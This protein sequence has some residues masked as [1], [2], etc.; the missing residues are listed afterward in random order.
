[1]KLKKSNYVTAALLLFAL[2]GGARKAEAINVLTF[3]GAVSQSSTF[4]ALGF[5]VTSIGAGDLATVDFNQYDVIYVSQTYQELLSGPLLPALAGRASDLADY[6]AAGGGVVFGSPA[7][8]GGVGNNVILDPSHPILN[9]PNL[10]DVSGL[11]LQGL[12][13]PVGGLLDAVATD[14]DGNPTIVAGEIGSGRIVGWNPDPQYESGITDAGIQ[15][16]DNSITWAAGSEAPIPEPS[17]IALV[18]VGLGGLF[19][20]RKRKQN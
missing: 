20:A 19:I 7:L 14:E 18:T 5:S 8:A 9:S 1:M 17:T 4:N 6:V 15:L 10:L 12:P 16:V 11:G 13:L 2:L 3:D